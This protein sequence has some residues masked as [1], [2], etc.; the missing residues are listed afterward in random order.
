MEFSGYGDWKAASVKGRVG[1]GLVLQLLF[2]LVRG[3]RWEAGSGRSVDG[4]ATATLETRG[5]ERNGMRSGRR[6]IVYGGLGLGL[7]WSD[8]V[9]VLMLGK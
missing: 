3:C 4:M 8:G 2:S 7:V 1:V 9:V 6:S 5:R